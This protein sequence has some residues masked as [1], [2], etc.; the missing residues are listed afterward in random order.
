[1]YTVTTRIDM[2][3]DTV[4]DAI[5]L[6]RKVIREHVKDRPGFVSSTFNYD[7]ETAT[8]LVIGQ[9]ENLE[10]AKALV[11]SDDYHQIVGKFAP[12][13]VGEPQRSMYEVKVHITPRG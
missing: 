2:K 12:Y 13:I 5:S 1:M 9:W 3:P 8:A 11:E 6:F 7:F 4:D 10:S